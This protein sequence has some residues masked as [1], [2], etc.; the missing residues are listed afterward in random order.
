MRFLGNII[1]GRS[2]AALSIAI[3]GSVFPGLLYFEWG[4]HLGHIKGTVACV[5]ADT[6][7]SKNI[8]DILFETQVCSIS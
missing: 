2:G 4:R 7:F 8:N 5:D 3:F 6:S 1:I